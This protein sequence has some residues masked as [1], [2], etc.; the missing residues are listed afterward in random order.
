L[1]AAEGYKGVEIRW[2]R[3]RACDES[4]TTALCGEADGPY[5]CPA[6]EP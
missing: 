4:S 2:A 1:V 3:A 6:D 5:P